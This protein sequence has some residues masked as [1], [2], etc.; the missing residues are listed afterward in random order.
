MQFPVVKE[1]IEMQTQELDKESQPE[2]P[3]YYRWNYCQCFYCKADC[4]GQD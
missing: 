4:F 1:I 2:E 3:E